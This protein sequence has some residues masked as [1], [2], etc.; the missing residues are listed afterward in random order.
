MSLSFHT[1]VRELT[2]LLRCIC[3]GV[4][5]SILLLLTLGILSFQ[6]IIFSAPNW[7]VS[8]TLFHVRATEPLLLAAA[9]LASL[10][11]KRV[12]VMAC[13]FLFASVSTLVVLQFGEWLERKICQ[14]IVSTKA[15]EE[16]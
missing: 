14:N 2:V 8:G 4:W 1:L 7:G 6:P 10:G 15:I 11:S 5:P 12:R 13:Y 9:I 16:K 3:V